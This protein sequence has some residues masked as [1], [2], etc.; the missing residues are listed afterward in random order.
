MVVLDIENA[1]KAWDLGGERFDE[2]L[3]P[4]YVTGT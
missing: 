3:A 2:H 1:K 4:D